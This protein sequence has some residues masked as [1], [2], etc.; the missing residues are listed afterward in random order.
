MRFVPRPGSRSGVRHDTAGD[1][2]DGLVNLFDLALVLAVG[3]LLAA[4]SSLGAGATLGQGDGSDTGKVLPGP[5]PTVG[6]KLDGQG[7]EVGK[8]YRLSDGRYVYQPG[9]TAA[10]S[11][12]GATPQPKSGAT[13]PAGASPQT[14]QPNSGG[15]NT[16]LSTGVTT[17]LNR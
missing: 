16:P 9:P 13:P 1:P 14:S 11:S 6:E 17:P 3:L 4:F 5:P 15:G 10:T 12:T 8:V 7:T 2:L